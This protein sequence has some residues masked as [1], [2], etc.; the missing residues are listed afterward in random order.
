MPKLREIYKRKYRNKG[1]S[2]KIGK[3]DYSYQ[4]INVTFKYSVKEWNR[5]GKR[6]YVK[7]GYDI[8]RIRINDC[9]GW[10]DGEII[11]VKTDTECSCTETP[12]PSPF[13]Y[14][15][16]MYK[17]VKQPKTIKT[18]AE[19]RTQ[20]Y[21]EG[22]N[23]N[24]IH[25]VRMKRSS[26]ASRVGK[27]LFVNE[28]LYK[29]MH[30]WDMCGLDIKPGQEIDLAA[31]EAYIALPLSSIIDT[32]EIDPK[33]IL[34]IDDYESV[35]KDRVIATSVVDGWLRSEEKEVTVANSIWD[36][37]GLLDV[38]M[39][40]KY[41]DKG[42]LL[43]RNRF[44]K[45]C[46]FNTNIQKFFHDHNITS[47]DQ[48]NGFTLAGGIED[49]K[50][51]VTPSSIKYLKFGSLEQWLSNI[52]PTFGVVKYDKPTH[53][54]DGRMVQTHYQLLN[55]LQ[56]S[57]NEMRE[58]LQ[59][60][61]DF[62]NLLQ[63]EPAAVRYF[64]KYPED[65]EYDGVPMKDRNEVVY[66]LMSLNE[67]FTETKYYQDFVNN[68]T[69]S[70]YKNLKNGHVYVN[71]NYSTLFGNPLEMLY[72]SICMFDGES[73]LGVGNIHSTRFRYDQY[74]L[75][76]RSPHVTMGN[77]LVAYNVANEEIDEYFNL[78]PQIVCVNSIGE[79]LLQRLSGADF[80]SDTMLITDNPI[81]IKAAQKNYE[82]FKPPTSLVQA[83]KHKRY[84]TP[85]QQADLDIRTSVNKIGEIINLSQVLNSLYWDRIAHGQT[86]EDNH[87]LYCDIATLDVLSNIEIDRAK[88]EFEIDSVKELNKLR[89]KYNVQLAERFQES[90]KK[91]LP[92]FFSHISRQKG[93]YDP[94]HKKY[95]KHDTSMDYLQSIVTGFRI[96]HPQRK[97][98]LPFVNVLDVEKYDK[99]YVN[100]E[101]TLRI[102]DA[103]RE[104]SASVRDVY[105]NSAETS[106]LKRALQL[107]LYDEL[108][109]KI[110][111]ERIGYNTMYY[112]LG[113]I[114]NDEYRDVKH[115]LL[116]VLFQ[117]SNEAFCSALKISS[118]DI[119]YLIPG[120]GQFVV[121][122]QRMEK[123]ARPWQSF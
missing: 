2:F 53:F 107:N 115:K 77:I 61:L 40:G 4:T 48:L 37:Q 101:Q 83:K 38:S 11:A 105:N 78:T 54:F 87:E 41:K 114:E 12:L 7:L 45:C 72:S 35:F 17:C 56:L 110:N 76:S 26:G 34:V 97:E 62:A 94:V 81:L 68:L 29:A 123:V 121:Y 13:Q 28:N 73:K 16:G 44:F 23:C 67:R 58:F 27:C 80:D 63:T 120:N 22:F 119:C 10:A 102:I 109:S 93:Y 99:R 100:M 46:C 57:K 113:L 85:E 3:K 84:Y 14:S 18:C 6:L 90:N 106:D 32:I 112:L 25:Y 117:S 19:L 65:K 15:D 79:N 50:L 31:L 42:M 75:G 1:F 60:S 21:L 69:K 92:Y 91:I 104:Y 51:I 36:G 8:N 9:L 71:G 55:T 24:G 103:I 59:P 47:I 30:V 95:V 64:I 39:F 5:I 66:N 111:S 70:F 20:L 96:K 89:D 108:V 33:S 86:H 43:L 82:L 49:I 98:F 118:G 116:T 88:K 74:L 52:E 122:G